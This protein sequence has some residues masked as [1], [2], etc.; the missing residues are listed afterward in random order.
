MIQAMIKYIKQSA[1]DGIEEN[2]N[3]V[4]RSLHSH[5]VIYVF[6]PLLTGPR[7]DEEQEVEK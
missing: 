3:D 4:S 7:R 2:P 6:T 5:A 1:V